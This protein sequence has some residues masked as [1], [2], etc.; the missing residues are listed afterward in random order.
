MDSLIL[1][2]KFNLSDVK[3]RMSYHV[4]LSID[5]VHGGKTIG[6]TIVDEVSSTSVMS[7]SC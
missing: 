4:A 6:R 3:I 2:A 5:V 1:L 7:I